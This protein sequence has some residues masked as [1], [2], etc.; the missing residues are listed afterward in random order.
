AGDVAGRTARAAATAATPRRGTTSNV[1]RMVRFLCEF[2]MGIPKI[3]DESNRRV[4]CA[5]TTNRTNRVAGGRNE[6]ISGDP[7]RHLQLDEGAECLD[8][9]AGSRGLWS[10]GPATRSASLRAVAA[11]CIR[12]VAIRALRS[13]GS[14]R[15]G[16]AFVSVL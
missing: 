11:S 4:V 5:G 15:R 8:L 9:I 1:R 13:W 10:V 12:I 7:A 2:E 3:I 14:D 16:R 6:A